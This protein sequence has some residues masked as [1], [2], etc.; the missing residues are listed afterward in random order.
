V[1]SRRAAAVKQAGIRTV[2]LR[3]ARF[4]ME[5]DFCR[6][7][8]MEQHGLAVM[9]S[10]PAD[11]AIAHRVIYDE[12]CRSDIRAESRAQYRR[13]MQRLV[14]A[15][16]ERIILGCTEIGLLVSPVDAPVPLFDTTQLHAQAAALW[17]LDDS[18]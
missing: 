15:G 8:L 9:I 6:G 5:R 4:T 1:I 12:L 17:A 2:G 11:R 3:G 18:S 7:R 14:E 16:A 13:I 10:D